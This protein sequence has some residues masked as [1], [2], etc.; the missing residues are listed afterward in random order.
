MLGAYSYI[1][2]GTH[3]TD[4]V[5]VGRYTSIANLCT[6]GAARHDYSKFTS[7]AFGS[8]DN[9]ET[10]IGHDV[11]IGCNSVVLSGVTICTGAVIGAGSVVTRDVPFYAIAYGVPARVQRY[12]F[13][14]RVIDALL[15]CKWWEF[16]IEIVSQLPRDPMDAVKEIE[17]LRLVAQGVD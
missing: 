15:A 3:I 2:A 10:L 13:T 11:W 4:S 9:R 12:R 8:E 6:L 16:P 7:Y 17:R 5:K 1:G 14:H